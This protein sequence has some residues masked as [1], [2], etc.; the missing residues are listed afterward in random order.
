MA[1]SIRLEIVTP[2]RL[3]YDGEVELV[4]VRTLSGDEGFMARHA[5]ACKLLQVGE[6]WIQEAG[7]KKFKVAAAAAGYIDVKNEITIFT[8]A[9]E[10][11]EEI[12]LQRSKEHKAHAE[13]YLS[14][15]TEQDS[16]TEEFSKMQVS[17]S[18]ALTRMSVVDGGSRKGKM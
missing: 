11:P 18:K 1:D 6:I 16:D 8:D 2:E 10:W 5:W 17:L 9:A 15:H 12:D 13:Q 14:T 3:F 4:I 7:S